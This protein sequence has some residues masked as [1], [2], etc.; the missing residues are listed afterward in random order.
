MNNGFDVRPTGRQQIFC[1]FFPCLLVFGL[2]AAL[3]CASSAHAGWRMDVGGYSASTHS[4][5][6]VG[7]TDC[8]TD[9]GPEHPD[10]ALVNDGAQKLPKAATCYEC[11][12]EVEEQL[13]TDGHGGQKTAPDETVDCVSCHAPH[14]DGAP[15]ATLPEAMPEA[16]AKCLSCHALPGGD[17]DHVLAANR[18]FCLACHGVDST[19]EAPHLDPATE[20]AA[21]HADMDCLACHQRADAFPHSDQK[22]TDCLACHERSHKAVAHDE[23]ISVTCEACHV[24]VAPPVR[25]TASGL[26]VRKTLPPSQL[27][28]V[29]GVH[30]MNLEPGQGCDRCHH[31]ATKV[32]AAAM[33]LPAKSVAC[34]ACH[35]ATFTASD[36]ISAISLLILVCGLLLL[37]GL[38]LGGARNVFR[39]LFAGMRVLFSS[40]FPAI[41]SSLFYDVLLQRRLYRLSPRRWCIHA[42]IFFPFLIRFS[43]GLAALLGANL[44]P[45]SIWVWW[46]VDKNHPATAL[47][48]D[49]TGVALL[50]GIALAW[51]RGT[52]ADRNLLPGLPRQDRL[53]LGLIAG[54]VVVGFVLEGMRMAMTMPPAGAHYAFLGSLLSMP[55]TGA[56]WLPKAYGYV[57]YVHALLTGAFL[58]YLPFSKLTHVILAPV[59]LAINAG[60]HHESQ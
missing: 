55:F 54:I 32:G 26:V 10:P 33:V 22:R 42:L 36:P 52:R 57:W 46:L 41:A 7:C 44:I 13:Q 43:W 47:L 27:P 53:A 28:V 17:A 38:Y 34:M 60:R 24:G 3:L 21:P 35:A 14:T 31:D 5:A 9:V 8:H 23:H 29:E 45:A 58:A 30:A 51:R 6:G 12:P 50:V 20:A 39:M 2:C 48:F 37:T 11:H 19:K 25:D 1:T 40:R 18:A 4:K 16:D 59:A 56:E 15:Q 49:L